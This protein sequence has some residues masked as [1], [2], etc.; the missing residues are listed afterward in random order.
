[1]KA[2]ERF[3]QSGNSSVSDPQAHSSHAGD[4]SSDPRGDFDLTL[5]NDLDFLE[6]YIKTR[7]RSYTF[8]NALVFESNP[9]DQL[10]FTHMELEKGTEL[11]IG[12]HA[13]EVGASVNVAFLE[14]EEWLLLMFIAVSELGSLGSRTSRKRAAELRNTVR[15][16]WAR[17]QIHKEREW[18]RQKR[19]QAE[20]KRTGAVYIDSSKSNTGR[21]VI[22]LISSLSGR[23]F[24]DV[25]QTEPI[26]MIHHITALLMHLIYRVPRR[27]TRMLLVALRLL[28]RVTSG[29]GSD[30]EK[31]AMIDT[32]PIDIRTILGR[33][34]LDPVTR[35]Y[36]CCPSCFAIYSKPYPETCSHRR[37]FL[38]KP[39]GAKLWR[40]RTIRGREFTFPIRIFL[41][42]E[43]KGWLARMLSRKDIE[44]VMDKMLK[45]AAGAAKPIMMDLWDAPV[46]RELRTE[47]GNRFVDAPP[48]EGR[49]IFGLSLDGF[50]PFQNKEAKQDVTVTGIYVYCLNLPPHLRYR[51]E[52]MYLV[53]VIP[54][55]TKPSI[56]QINHFLRPLVDELLEF[57]FKGVFYSRTALYEAGR[58]VRAAL[59]PL[60]CDLPAARQTAGFGGHGAKYFC[61]VCR[62]LKSDMNELDMSK[63]EERTCDEHRA[64]AQAWKDLPT[65]AK[66]DTAFKLNSTRW[67]ALL[68]LPYWDPI[69][70]TV[71]DSMHNHYL[72]LLK[73]HCRTLWGM[74][75]SSVDADS[76]NPL[77]DAPPS[78]EDITRG[79]A[80]LEEGTEDELSTCTR[81][82][83]NY[84]CSLFDIP[85]KKHSKS[86]MISRILKFVSC[87]SNTGKSG[88]TCPSCVA[89]EGNRSGARY[90]QA[91]RGAGRASSFSN[92]NRCSVRT[93]CAHVRSRSCSEVPG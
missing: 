67:S 40:K 76:N 70:Y 46:F 79:L 74:N 63:W 30:P 53:G 64:A 33:F 16:E 18:R 68:D 6:V 7:I 83:L 29:G 11:N 90:D 57:W 69:K 41:Y 84:L 39:C 92:K 5:M 61:S 20:C 22:K 19:T 34:D 31:K 77:E 88:L 25:E 43:M 56:D 45:R 60:V 65:L 3:A 13:L 50:N 36:A 75:V 48:G 26:L 47:D 78:E 82:T 72:G 85:R 49:L 38:S 12:P 51:P 58:L 2:E 52:N 32:L 54:G 28:V 71:I 17:M 87:V 62:L 9:V 89:S 66:R 81:A 73:Y 59:V 21:M 24:V 23:Y 1:M 80:Y 15:Q 10:S 93:K 35:A 91:L 55:P 42:Q 44:D 27:A 4:E 14:Q 86:H 37:A 8:N